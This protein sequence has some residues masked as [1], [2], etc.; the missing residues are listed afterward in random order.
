MDVELTILMPCLNEEETLAVCINK[1]RAFLDRCGICGEILIADNGSTDASVA[2]A[3]SLGARVI[4]VAEKGYGAA[5]SG[6]I[7]V[8]RGVYIIMGDAD[9]SYDFSD[10]SPYVDSLRQGNQLVMGNRFKGGIAPGAMPFLHKY[11]GNPVLSFL[12]RTFYKIPVGDFHCGLRGFDAAAVRE[13]D[14]QTPGMEFASEM[15]VK[16]AL[17]GLKIAE[18]PTTLAKDGRNRRPHL[19]TF[20]DGWRHLCFLLALTPKWL[21]LYPGMFFSFVGLALIG[22]LLGGPLHLGGVELDGKALIFGCLSLLVGLQSITFGLITRNYSDRIGALPPSSRSDKLSRVLT[23]D[24][25]AALSGVLF[26]I[27]TLAA[28]YCVFSWANAGL[29]K[30]DERHFQVVTILAFT[31]FAASFQLFQAA[32]IYEIMTLKTANRD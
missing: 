29:G 11:L 8:A 21:F 13:L 28:L 22:L 6:G 14:L 20:R 17:H 3:E 31:C 30:L 12:G 26:L 25:M 23:R 24:R 15:V 16:S 7:K 10:L 1:A 32:F 9:D 18:V 2:I 5:L 19:R 4:H 27:G